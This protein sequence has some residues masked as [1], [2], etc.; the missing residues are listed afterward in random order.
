MSKKIDTGIKYYLMW[1]YNEPIHPKESMTKFT[2]D[3][4]IEMTINGPRL[5]F[6]ENTTLS[7]WKNSEIN[8]WE[9]LMGNFKKDKKIVSLGSK[10]K[11][12]EVEIKELES[13]DN[14]IRWAD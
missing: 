14:F 11:P 1:S 10:I 5:M 6:D 3:T 9:L 13:D 8:K 4:G 12:T 7:Q 2:W